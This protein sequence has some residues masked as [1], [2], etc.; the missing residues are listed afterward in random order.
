MNSQTADKVQYYSRIKSEGT[1]GL[2]L[3]PEL[4]VCLRFVC[5]LQS[6]CLVINCQW[7]DTDDCCDPKQAEHVS[8]TSRV[9]GSSPELAML[10]SV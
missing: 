9:A 2:V 7:C 10:C 5:A 6:G 8:G 1:G 3:I 4:W